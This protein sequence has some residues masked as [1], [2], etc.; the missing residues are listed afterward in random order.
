MLSN[1]PG[2]NNTEVNNITPTNDNASINVNNNSNMDNTNTYDITPV[3]SNNSN[4]YNNNTYNSNNYNSNNYNSNGITNTN[5]D[6][7]NNMNHETSDKNMLKTSSRDNTRDYA[8]NMN[9]STCVYVATHKDTKTFVISDSN[10][11]E[12]GRFSS[13]QLIKYVVKAECGDIKSF[14]KLVDSSSDSVI[15]KY[16]G[17][18]NVENGEIEMINYI[19]SPFMGSVE[20]LVNLYLFINSFEKNE[21]TNEL[22]RNVVDDKQQ[23][24]I[25]SA[26]SS[27]IYNLLTHTMKVITA[28]TNKI[29]ESGI[30]SEND[31]SVK[32]S[33]LVYGASIMYR[34]SKFVQSSI[35]KSNERIELSMKKISEFENGRNMIVNKIESM[36]KI[37]ETQNNRINTLLTN[38]ALYQ[39]QMMNMTGGSSKD[40]DYD[41]DE[42]YEYENNLDSPNDQYGIIKNDFIS[43]FHENSELTKKI[44]MIIGGGAATSDI[45][46]NVVTSNDS[47]ITSNSYYDDYDSYDNTSNVNTTNNAMDISA[48][49][50][51]DVNTSNAAIS[52]SVPLTN[53]M[54]GGKNKD[55]TSSNSNITSNPSSTSNTIVQLSSLSIPELNVKDLKLEDLLI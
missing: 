46:S 16:I 23:E 43:E 18:Y 27:L 44:D 19:D 14:L 31:K 38:T 50:S 32:E 42:K 24:C 49:T 5:T 30:V 11:V 36:E 22:I 2:G 35:D 54:I 1:R 51:N 12:I 15:E 4:T 9:T 47:N 48:N 34:L 37:I 40:D 13:L 10:G 7:P 25:R 21:L 29:N 33:L 6:I 8:I 26:I 45:T 55:V 53:A 52:T 17:K 3:N 20:T 39:N 28:I 41:S